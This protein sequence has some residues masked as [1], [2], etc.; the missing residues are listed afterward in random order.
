M[1]VIAE[2]H[3]DESSARG[4]AHPAAGQAERGEG[5]AVGEPV[6][7]ARWRCVPELAGSLFTFVLT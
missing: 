7:S 5:E 2:G 4:P 3:G 6:H 1:L